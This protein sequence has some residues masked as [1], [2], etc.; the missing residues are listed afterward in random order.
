MLDQIIESVLRVENWNDQFRQPNRN[1]KY[2]LCKPILGDRSSRCERC[3]GQAGHD[4][5]C[6]AVPRAER[7]G[8]DYATSRAA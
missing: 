8:P 4:R 6:F 7:W 5:P 3:G 1:G 2:P